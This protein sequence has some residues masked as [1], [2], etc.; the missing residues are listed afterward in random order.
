MKYD[1]YFILKKDNSLYIILDIFK[2]KELYLIGHWV[3]PID[4]KYINSY[5]P[6]VK[7]VGLF[8]EEDLADYK[9]IFQY[10][11]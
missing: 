1:K 11:K 4:Y 6:E 2:D 9:L 8:S 3:Y 7:Y 5:G 10:M